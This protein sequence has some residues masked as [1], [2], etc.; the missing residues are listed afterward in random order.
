MHRHPDLADTAELTATKQEEAHKAYKEAQ[1]VS[2]AIQNS[3]SASDAQRAFEA[4]SR[5]EYLTDNQYDR[6][7]A[8]FQMSRY[9]TLTKVGTEEW[10]YLRGVLAGE[11]LDRSFGSGL[12]LKGSLGPEDIQEASEDLALVPRTRRPYVG[13]T[14][15]PAP[16]APMNLVRAYYRGYNSGL[17]P[18]ALYRR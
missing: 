5:F 14:I 7:E 9:A 17:K 8:R 3:R 18:P 4:W 16:L 15:P 13:D 10:A 12:E 6:K 1:K 11:A 2:F